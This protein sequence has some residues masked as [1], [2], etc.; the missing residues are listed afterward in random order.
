MLPRRRPPKRCPDPG[1]RAADGLPPAETDLRQP[2]LTDAGAPFTP[3]WRFLAMRS[4]TLLFLA[5]VGPI[6]VSSA[7]GCNGCSSSSGPESADSGETPDVSVD[8]GTTETDSS[9]DSSTDSATGSDTSTP[10]NDAGTDGLLRVRQRP[11]PHAP[12][13]GLHPGIRVGHRSELRQ[14]P[15]DGAR[16]ERRSDVRLRGHRVRRGDRHAAC[17]VRRSHQPGRV[18]RGLLHALGPVRGRLHDPR[19]HRSH[20]QLQRRQPGHP[21]HLRRVRREHARDSGW[22][23]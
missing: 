21:A 3:C 9:T 7:A 16:R 8:T 19:R 13:G 22:R 15:V 23:T 4:R 20:R 12:A 10:M 1:P 6:L 2:A 18:R 17:G 14:W 11:H 5:A